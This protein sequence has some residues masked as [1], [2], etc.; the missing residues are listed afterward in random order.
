MRASLVCHPDTPCAAITAIDVEVERTGANTLWLRYE[1]AG[2]VDL[3]VWPETAAPER[4]DGLWRRTCFEAFVHGL[5]QA[6]REFN[7]SPSGA[8]A[9]YDFEGYRS[10]MRPARADSPEIGLEG[11]EAFVALEANATLSAGSTRLGL[12][13]VIEQVDGSLSYWALAH[14]PG[15]PDFHNA[16]CFTLQLPAPNSP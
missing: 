15:K 9:A 2:D 11:A 5:G 3:V 8:W 13:A 16:D 1:L 7:F 4:V 6:Y 10:G 12:T 14:A